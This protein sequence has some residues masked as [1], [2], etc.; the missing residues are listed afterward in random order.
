M[1]SIA[2]W[3]DNIT[4]WLKI[5]KEQEILDRQYYIS[6]RPP[7]ST[8]NTLKFLEKKKP[9][10]QYFIDFKFLHQVVSNDMTV[11]N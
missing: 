1:N 9:K 3:R 5:I 8:M 11:V 7:G 6:E 4:I 2:F 10:F